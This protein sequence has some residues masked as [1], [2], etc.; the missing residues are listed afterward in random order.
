[1]HKS[2]NQSKYLGFINTRD[3]IQSLVSDLMNSSPAQVGYLDRTGHRRC[4][5]RPPRHCHP[6]GLILN[7]PHQ[8][9]QVCVQGKR[10]RTISVS[11]HL[12]PTT[13]LT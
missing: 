8:C 13:L 2:S 3:Y 5:H 7:S 6:C 11:L 10:I 1:V 9:A 12:K 4:Q